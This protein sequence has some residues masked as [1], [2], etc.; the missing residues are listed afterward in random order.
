ML[1]K[2]EI[3][4]PFDFQGWFWGEII[5]LESVRGRQYIFVLPY[6]REIIEK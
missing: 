3:T 2:I 6:C 5:T 4:T 1:S